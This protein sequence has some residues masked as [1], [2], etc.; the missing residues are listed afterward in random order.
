[1]SRIQPVFVGKNVFV[2]GATGFFGRMLVEKLL[3]LCPDVLVRTRKGKM[4]MDRLK[5]II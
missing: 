2:S 5:E 4:L 3:R 1:M